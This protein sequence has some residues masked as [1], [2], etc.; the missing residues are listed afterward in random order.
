MD[1]SLLSG[2]EDNESL[3]ARFSPCKGERPHSLSTLSTTIQR[4]YPYPSP[5]TRLTAIE[6]VQ[7]G[8]MYSAKATK[9]L[10]T[11]EEVDSKRLLELAILEARSNISDVHPIQFGAA[12]I[13]DDGTIVTTRQASA[14]EY[15]CTLDA[16]S[17]LFPHFREQNATPLLLVQA[18]QFGIAHAPFAPARAFL[19]EHGFDSCQI[20]L[21]DAPISDNE[22][23]IFEIDKWT[24]KEVF[25][26]DLARNLPTWTKGTSRDEK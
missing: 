23:D 2:N 22:A 4:L 24:L 26:S 13:F 25:V 8:E 16:V 15:G 1:E 11:L 10:E 3:N 20:I 21:H 7:L 6:S 17:Q 9:D 18:D 12:A 19:T 5:Y 14:L